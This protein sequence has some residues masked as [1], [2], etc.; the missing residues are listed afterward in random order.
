MTFAHKTHAPNNT[1]C[2]LGVILGYCNLV[3][4]PRF[5]ASQLVRPEVA[6]I[7]FQIFQFSHTR[8]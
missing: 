7:I 5:V 4:N 6:T 1:A 2:I 8:P 3:C